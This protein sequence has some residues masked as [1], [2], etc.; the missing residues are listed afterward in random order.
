MWYVLACQPSGIRALLPRLSL[1]RR[2]R[3]GHDTINL[4]E[5]GSGHRTMVEA[6]PERGRP[7]LSRTWRFPF[8]PF[9]VALT[10]KCQLSTNSIK[11]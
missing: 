8:Q 6:C 1:G 3:L 5:S 9:D 10:T 2:Q 4:H 7:I 11:K